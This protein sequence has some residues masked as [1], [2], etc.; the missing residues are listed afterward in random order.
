MMRDLP[1]LARRNNV[2]LYFIPLAPKSLSNFSLAQGFALDTDGRSIVSNDISANLEQ[3]LEHQ[4]G[5][6]MLGYRPTAGEAGKKARTVRVRTTKPG[7]DL[8]VRRIYEPPPPE[9][10]AARSAPPLPVER[11]DVEKAIDALPPPR[12]DGEVAMQ[13][14]SRSDVVDVTVEIASRLM[15]TEPW[16]SGGRVAVSLRDATGVVIAS[17]DAT[18]SAGERGARVRIP[19][20]GAQRPTRATSQIT[21]D[22]GATL[23]DAMPLVAPDT[24]AIGIPVLSRAGALP[25]LPFVP[26]AEFTFGRTE[27]LRIEWPLAG[28]VSDA[29]V[30]LR[31]ARGEEL[32]A[33]LSLTT[34]E[35]SPA[36]LR[37]DARLLSLAPGTY[38]FEATGE[39]SGTMVR[40][41]TA[42]RV[43]R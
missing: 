42:I 35:G 41:L 33:D 11:T 29:R 4:T 5:F 14:V 8:D 43:T 23:S 10:V 30:R 12:E 24:G 18:I 6:Y 25:R 21:H 31:N 32:P 7:V 16:R 40:Q 3:V 19:V 17:A 2:A 28:A 38:V 34:I 9:F 1:D 36:I 39:I 26:A 15:S 22:S 13:A 37:A 20:S 27:R